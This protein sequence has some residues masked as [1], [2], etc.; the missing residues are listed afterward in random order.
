[1]TRKDFEAIAHTLDANEAPLSL[2]SD[3][4]DMCAETNANFDRRRFVFAA[5]DNLRKTWDSE[6]RMLARE[7]AP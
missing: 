5:T 3:F 2:V 6:A 1:M 4:A 7:I